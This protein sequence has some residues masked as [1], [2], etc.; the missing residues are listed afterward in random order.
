MSEEHNPDGSGASN[1]NRRAVLKSLGATAAV[2][3]GGVGFSMPVAAEDGPDV[4]RQEVVVSESD[5][6]VALEQRVSR[7]VLEEASLSSLN[8]D[9]AEGYEIAVN[10]G[11]TSRAF[12]E[13]VIPST[14]G[15]ASFSYVK[16]NDA[17]N[18]AS[19][20]TET[21]TIIRATARDDGIKTEILEFGEDVTNEAVQTL[22][23]S[24]KK[25]DIEKNDVSTLH[26]NQ[27]AASFDKTSET[28]YLYIPATMKTDEKAMVFAEIPGSGNLDS[29]YVIQQSYWGCVANCII[30][31]SG[32]IGS[33]CWSYA[34]GA[35]AAQIY[36]SCAA[37]LACAGGIAGLCGV[38]CGG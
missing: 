37:C 1:V 16:S 20:K 28:T 10:A 2:G 35:C 36:P 21:G 5:V 33:W 4:E 27:A 6:Q 3:V 7:I 15:E 26:T 17:N 24:G 29:V 30:L 25:A 38:I 18:V 11:G 8:W 19:V 12:R 13:V 14:G 9:K 22:R 23:Q 34:C 31:H 32:A